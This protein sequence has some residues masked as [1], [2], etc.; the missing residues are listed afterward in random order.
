MKATFVGHA[1]VLVEANGISILSDPWWQ[2]P[3]FGAQW[4][5]YPPPYLAPVNDRKI[6][7]I[8]VSHGHHDH[9]HPGTL[10]SFDRSTKI[11]VSRAAGLSQGLRELGFTVVEVPDDDRETDLGQGVKVRIR[12]THGDDTL[13]C[14]TDG[15]EVL[16]N[17]N[18]ALH[19]ATPDVQK[20]FVD[21]LRR[22]YPSIDY[23]FCGYG[24]ASHFPNCYIVPGQDQAKTAAN[25]QAY[26]NRRWVD[27][28][29]G[30]QP[31]FAF[32]FAADVVFLEHDLRWANEPT[33][34]SE[35][36]TDVFTAAYPAAQTI[37][38]DIAP[39]FCI[40]DG[41][42]VRP[43]WRAPVRNDEIASLMP[44][45]IL[46]ANRYGSETPA[47]VLEVKR[48]LERNVETCHRYLTEHRGHYR[49][50]IR[51]RTATEGIEIAKSGS[52]IVVRIVPA[53]DADGTAYD[54]TFQTRLVYLKNALSTDYGHE[55][56]FVGSGGIFRYAGDDAVK[57]A[58]HAELIAVLRANGVAP[59]SRFGD[60][61]FARYRLKQL[62][63]KVLRVKQPTDLYDLQ[64]WTMRQD[65]S[66]ARA[67]PRRAVDSAAR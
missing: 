43:A 50:L 28:V 32:P 65:A 6:D 18:D 7:Y 54:L 36:P 63:K 41:V 1:A 26:F 48:L 24:V 27:L 66:P 16:V 31:R 40:E 53:E 14:V 64:A 56:P 39:G 29:H 46:R 51:F 19:S 30:L 45:Q 11:L 47:Q 67:Q 59:K 34:N 42:V 33:H 4:W 20:R 15:K 55:I 35:R 57:N 49:M 12:P 9:L 2:G 13:L 37:V 44:E 61:S 3:C 60:Q 23:L 25:R 52:R 5:I 21:M 22:D 17:L 62:V 8:Y 38:H 10:K 58:L